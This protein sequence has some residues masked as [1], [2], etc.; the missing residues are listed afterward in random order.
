MKKL[1]PFEFERLQFVTG[2]IYKEN[3]V[4]EEVNKL[5]VDESLL[6]EKKDWTYK[7]PPSQLINSSARAKNHKLYGKRFMTRLL[8]NDQGWAVKRIK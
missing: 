8:Q 6:V 3:P 1:S 2:S 4:I 5:A 7:S